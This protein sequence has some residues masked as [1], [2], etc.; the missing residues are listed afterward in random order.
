MYVQYDRHDKEKEGRVQDYFV[1]LITH[2]ISIILPS[3]SNHNYYN[4]YIRDQ[5]KLDNS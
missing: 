2:A 5:A 3:V 1:I 4:I